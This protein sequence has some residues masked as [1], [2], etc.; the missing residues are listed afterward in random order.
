VPDAHDP[1]KTHHPTVLT[2]D[3]ALRMDPG[4]EPISRHFLVNPDQLADAFARV[5]FKL[6]HLDMGPIQR[7][8][9]PL[10]PRETLIWQDPVPAVDHELVDV[11]DIAAL[12]TQILASGLSVSQLV[13]TA[14]ASAS[15]FRVS[16]KR[17][18]ANGARIRLEPQRNWAVNE[19][20]TLAR[21]LHTL[22]GIQ[23]SFNSAQTG[24]KRISL[25]D[26]IVL[27]GCAAVEKAANH[28]VQVPFA[29]G[30]T[31]ATQEWTDVESFA[32]LEPTADGFRN[33]QG[34]GNRVPLEHLLV[35]RANLLNLTAPEMTVL[36]GGLRV[37]GANRG[38]SPLGVLTS[39]PGL[40]TNDFFANLLDT[41][42]E[43]QPTSAGTFEG[44]DRATGEL[45]W[46]GSRADLAFGA[47]SELRAVAE[48]YASDDAKEKFVHDFVAAWDK[49]MNL[50]RYDLVYSS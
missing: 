46:T 24:A 26:L 40:L 42:T 36:V 27:G 12:K 32:A 23:E 3:L 28:E 2:T 6:T 14:W 10:V 15:T 31:D 35:D 19:P 13:S 8:L 37:L 20:D 18:G 41:G 39:T 45:T 44:R 38:Q 1:L 9:G 7:Y 21:V 29:P 4:Y 30:R 25:A 33:Y 11:S 16:D 5:W 50:D 17:G 22:E 48:V 43:W 49:V 47:N 34:R